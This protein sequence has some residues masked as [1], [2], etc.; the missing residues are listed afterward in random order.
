MAQGTQLQTERSSSWSPSNLQ[1][2]IRASVHLHFH[3]ISATIPN[4]HSED[5]EGEDG[6]D[7]GD[8][9]GCDGDDEMV[10]VMIIFL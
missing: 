7:G 6:D 9:D 2:G 4:A 10:T 3:S 1:A 8:G 5:G